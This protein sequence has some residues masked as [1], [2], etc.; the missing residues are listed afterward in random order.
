VHSSDDEPDVLVIDESPQDSGNKDKQPMPLVLTAPTAKL[1]S[2][3]F[4]ANHSK[5]GVFVF[6]SKTFT[7][8]ARIIVKDFKEFLYTIKQ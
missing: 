6:Y 5:S 2:C 4:R 3:R 8:F 7:G 1:V